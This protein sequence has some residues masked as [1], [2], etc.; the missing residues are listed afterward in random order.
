MFNPLKAEAN[1][2]ITD[3][4]IAMIAEKLADNTPQGSC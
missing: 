2:M 1:Q 3:G 4:D